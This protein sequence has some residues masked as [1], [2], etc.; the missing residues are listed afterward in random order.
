MSNEADGAPG[1]FS[2]DFS[3]TPADDI[4]QIASG[5]HQLDAFV[6][7]YI[8]E[9]LGYRFVV[10]SDG[11]GARELEQQV[12]SGAWGRGVPLLNPWETDAT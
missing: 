11:A 10:L 3:G 9:H 6:R 4:Q 2:F 12:R 7:R 8:H 5:R 1:G